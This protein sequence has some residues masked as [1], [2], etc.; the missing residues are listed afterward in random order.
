M[1]SERKATAK[2]AARAAGWSGVST[3][4][5]RFGGLAVGIVI[6]RVLTPEQFGIYAVALTVQSIL[7][8]V[9]D[10]GL[11]AELI[12]SPDPERR[13]PTVA[14]VGL[15]IGALLTLGSVLTASQVARL[16]DSPDAAPAIAVL[17][18]TLLLGGAGVVPYAYLQRR[19]QQ[20]ELFLIAGV[21]FVISTSV[22]LGLIALGW[23]VLGLA[24]GRLTAQVI[25]TVLQFVFAKT[26]PQ[27]SVDREVVRPVLAFSLPIAGANLLS[28]ALLNVDNVVIARV[29]GAT[30]LG[31]YVLA[32]NISNWPMSALSQMVRSVSLPFFAR[33]DDRAA[34]VV[35][36]LVGVAWAGALPAGVLLAVLSRSVIEFLYGAKWVPAAP[37]LAALGV[38]GSMRVVFDLFA[39]FLYAR[40]KSRPVLC[41]QLVWFVSI[42]IGMIVATKR[43][44]IVG[45]GWVHVLVAIGVI[46]PAYLIA[47]RF[48]GVVLVAFLR[49]AWL[50]TLSAIGACGIAALAAS[51]VHPPLIKLLV[52]GMAAAVT[53]AALIGRWILVRLR[54]MREAKDPRNDQAHED[55][56]DL[57]AAKAELSVALSREPKEQIPS[58]EQDGAP[59]GR[60]PKTL[61]FLTRK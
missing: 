25:T 9:A 20:R 21:D 44:G 42:V 10:L 59:N 60:S 12:R 29:A 2:T 51:S 49:E 19:F 23:G 16:L 3:I 4:V 31:Y 33:L 50:P 56:S 6:A 11:S 45:A 5:L 46:V 35:P 55:S 38:F 43:H 24:V 61:R 53:Y 28:W 47:L 32:F 22:T 58:T 7:M 26:P 14:T 40:G 48:A 13:A 41:V 8:T 37:V 54:S 27:F 39:G 52:G 57:T 34:D 36:R 1:A 18:F 17:A 15:T 30:A